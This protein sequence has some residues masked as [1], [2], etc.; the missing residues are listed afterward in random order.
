MYTNPIPPLPSPTRIHAP[1]SRMG[2][3]LITL[4]LLGISALVSRAQPQPTA[5]QPYQPPVTILRDDI[6]YDVEADGTFTNDESES[7]RINT[8]QGVKTRSQLPISFSTS[9][10]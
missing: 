2:S 8:D 10:Q 9:L 5:A 7:V 6:T 4:G 3:R 1:L